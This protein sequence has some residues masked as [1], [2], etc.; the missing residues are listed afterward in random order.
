M[1]RD[2]GICSPVYFKILSGPLIFV[3][4]GKWL[5]HNLITPFAFYGE[6]QRR[7]GW[8]TP[9]PYHTIFFLYH[10]SVIIKSSTTLLWYTLR[11]F[12]DGILQRGCRVSSTNIFSLKRTQCQRLQHMFLTR[13]LTLFW[14]EGR[15]RSESGSC[16]TLP[17]LIPRRWCLFGYNGIETSKRLYDFGWKGFRKKSQ[18]TCNETWKLKV[19]RI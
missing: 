2:T 17:Q 7:L 11:S 18:S 16:R 4:N 14:Q 5:C 6:I 3:V 12:Q 9:F 10:V 19:G 1:S 8:T 13:N 15:N